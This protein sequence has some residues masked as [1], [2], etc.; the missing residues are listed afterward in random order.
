MTIKTKAPEAFD[1]LFQDG[2]QVECVDGCTVREFLCLQMHVCGEYANE[3]IQTL[4]LNHKPVDDFD[5]AIIYESDSLA[6]SAAMPGLVGSTLRRGGYY[7][8]MRGSISYRQA[9]ERQGGKRCLVNLR[10]FN[11]LAKELTERFL[12]NGVYVRADKLARFFKTRSQ[13][14]FNV[15]NEVRVNGKR[16]SVG[17]DIGSMIPDQPPMVHLRLE[18]DA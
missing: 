2:V 4:F 6:L 5:T 1:F 18:Q 16:L 12:I 15:L 11:F 3:R 17:P 10:L 7:A 8:E 9:E 14:F 13:N